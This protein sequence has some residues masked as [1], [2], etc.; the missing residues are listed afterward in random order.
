MSKKRVRDDKNEE[1]TDDFIRVLFNDGFTSEN[2]MYLC[3]NFSFESVKSSKTVP[4]DIRNGWRRFGEE[5]G[6]T[7]LQ[8]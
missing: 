3:E 5:L 4:E 8:Y 2:K 7:K 6:S 1:T